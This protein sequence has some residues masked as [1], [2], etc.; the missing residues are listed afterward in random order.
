MLNGR[1]SENQQL[2]DS[3]RTDVFGLPSSGHTLSTLLQCVHS[4]KRMIL[5]FQFIKKLYLTFFLSIFFSFH[6]GFYWWCTF[7]PSNLHEFHSQWICLLCIFV[8][9]LVLIRLKITTCWT[10][11]WNFN[12]HHRYS[13][14][15]LY[16]YPS[17]SSSSWASMYIY[18]F[19]INK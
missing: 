18:T 5:Q 7:K 8:V 12:C 11:Y 14:Y 3:G 13:W 16:L 9:W 4:T 17:S 10:N 1:K 6:F 19:N 2:F 15:R